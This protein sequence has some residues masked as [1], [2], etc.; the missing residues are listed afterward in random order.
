MYQFVL[1]VDGVQVRI[2]GE[3][4]VSVGGSHGW[5]PAN[6]TDEQVQFIKHCYPIGDNGS[7][8][9]QHIGSICIP[10]MACDVCVWVCVQLDLVLAQMRE[11]MKTVGAEAT[12]LRR[13]P[14][15]NA[16]KQAAGA[17][18]PRNTNFERAQHIVPS[19]RSLA[20]VYWLHEAM[21]PCRW[22]K[23]RCLGQKICHRHAQ[24]GDQGGSNWECGQWEINSGKPAP[25]ISEKWMERGKRN[26]WI[27]VTRPPGQCAC[28]GLLQV[29]VITRNMLDD[30]RGLA[31]SKVRELHREITNM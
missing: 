31:R 18:L 21:C 13:S 4:L 14:P 9:N 30:G 28:F 17:V 6:L 10:P 22:G 19:Y 5:G 1:D 7:G 25:E 12:I 11:A 26:K 3:Q 24:H 15:A 20:G 29:G 2:V 8:C 16:T 27:I 23:C